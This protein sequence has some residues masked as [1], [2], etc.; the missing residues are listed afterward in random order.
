M[1]SFFLVCF[2][3]SSTYSDHHRVH[4]HMKKIASGW[5]LN[6]HPSSR[7]CFNTFLSRDIFRMS[8]R[9]LR[10]PHES[11]STCNQSQPVQTLN[12]LG[13]FF[14]LQK[15]NDFSNQHTSRSTSRKSRSPFNSLLVSLNID[16]FNDLLRSSKKIYE[17][18]CDQ[19]F[20]ILCVYL[21]NLL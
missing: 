4:V 1:Y 17:I 7:T 10:F 19:L 3:F 16:I 14:P 9:D 11:R 5:Y 13:D 6:D 21:S 12:K 8:C 15:E 18:D 20:L 2:C